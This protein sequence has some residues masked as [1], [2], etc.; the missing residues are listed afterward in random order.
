MD[1]VHNIDN[2]INQIAELQASDTTQYTKA[3]GKLDK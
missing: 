1:F 2:D 3:W